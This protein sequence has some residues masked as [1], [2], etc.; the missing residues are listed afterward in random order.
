MPVAKFPSRGI[1]GIRRTANPEARA[2][3]DG[4]RNL[5]PCQQPPDSPADGLI[6]IDAHARV[7]E[8]SLREHGANVK[9]RTYG[10]GHGW[11]EYPYGHIRLGLLWLQSQAAAPAD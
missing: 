4:D 2:C 1:A 6:P 11:T 8:R 9:P 7:A 5:S 10:G 3:E